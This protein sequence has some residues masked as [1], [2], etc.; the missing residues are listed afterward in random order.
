MSLPKCKYKA[1]SVVKAWNSNNIEANQALDFVGCPRCFWWHSCEGRE[2]H[3]SRLRSRRNR[4]NTR[5]R[6]CSQKSDPS[7]CRGQCTRVNH[8]MTAW[9]RKFKLIGSLKTNSFQF[10]NKKKRKRT[11]RGKRRSN[12]MVEEEP[13]GYPVASLAQVCAQIETEI[14]FR[15]LFINNN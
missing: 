11:S 13:M 8:V 7:T 14:F 1:T 4:G 3:L 9:N 15:F 5:R 6:G 2:V 12:E 10:G